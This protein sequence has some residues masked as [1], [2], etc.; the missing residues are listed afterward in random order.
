M[1]YINIVMS[2]ITT[3]FSWFMSVVNACGM[4]SYVIGIFILCLVSR[5]LL[6]PLFGRGYGDSADSKK[7]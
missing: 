4:W 1:I 6:A 5:F 2:V 7:E 3:M